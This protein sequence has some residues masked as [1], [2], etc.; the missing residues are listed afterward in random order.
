MNG[1]NNTD[2]LNV[3]TTNPVETFD[4]Q[5][6]SINNYTLNPDIKDKLDNENNT[7]SYLIRR[8]IN[9]NSDKLLGNSV[10]IPAFF[11]GSLYYFYRKMYLYGIVIMIIE[12]AIMFLPYYYFW[13]LVVRLLLLFATNKIY[14]SCVYSDIQFIKERSKDKTRDELAKECAKQ[15]GASIGSVFVGI[16]LSGIISV[17]VFFLLARIG[18]NVKEVGNIGAIWQNISAVEPNNYNGN[19]SC[20]YI[21]LKDI[22]YEIPKD[23]KKKRNFQEIKATYNKDDVTCILS[24]RSVSLYKDPE[25]LS[26]Q[27]ANYY[28]ID[29]N[30]EI[31]NGNTWKTLVLNKGAIST[32]YYVGGFENDVYI[33]SYRYNDSSCIGKDKTFLENLE[34]D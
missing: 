7:D 19:L 12:T 27:M 3:E 25:T 28:G 29:L 16:I 1:N 17:L 2:N 15:G 30:E 33:Y 14:I 23:F 8:Y 4:A 6:N 24:L 9:N 10:N 34:I 20:N 22:D 21:I 32:K 26:T 5:A 13:L 31:I 18:I 11:L